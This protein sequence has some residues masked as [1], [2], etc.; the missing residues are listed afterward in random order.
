MCECR[1]GIEQNRVDY[2]VQ[3]SVLP[4]VKKEICVAVFFGEILLCSNAV[5]CNSM[6]FLCS[7]K[8]YLGFAVLLVCV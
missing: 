6:F 5:N 2:C 8:C 7:L 1:L 4:V 3:L